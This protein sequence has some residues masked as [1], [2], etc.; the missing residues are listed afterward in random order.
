MRQWWCWFRCTFSQNARGDIVR[1]RGLVRIEFQEEASYFISTTTDIFELLVKNFAHDFQ[2]ISMLAILY[3]CPHL[4]ISSVDYLINVL[5]VQR[6][7]F[8]EQFSG[9]A[10]R[11]KLSISWHIIQVVQLLNILQ[12]LHFD[13]FLVDLKFLQIIFVQTINIYIKFCCIFLCNTGSPNSIPN[14]CSN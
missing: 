4:S 10:R 14:L 11:L 2:G 7:A 6:L 8:S 1:P 9:K 12:G 5:K 13:C 3:Q